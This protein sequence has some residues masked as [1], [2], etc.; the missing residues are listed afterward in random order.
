MPRIEYIPVNAD[1]SESNPTIDVCIGCA[2]QFTEGDTMDG[3][4]G[5]PDTVDAVVGST[6]VELSLIH[7]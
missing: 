4:E 6:S 7:I 1:P 5:E 3:V 2:D